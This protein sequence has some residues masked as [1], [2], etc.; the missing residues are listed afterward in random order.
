MPQGAAR[1]GRRD[2]V[3]AHDAPAAAPYQTAS[4]TPPPFPKAAQ[5]CRRTLKLWRTVHSPQRTP[6]ARI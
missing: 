3:R 1:V 4:T 5:P 2:R 6:R